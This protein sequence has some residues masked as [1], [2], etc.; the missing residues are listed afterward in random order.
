MA[1]RKIVKEELGQMDEA[2]LDR[3]REA[4]RHLD[5]AFSEVNE[6]WYEFIENPVI[7]EYVNGYNDDISLA[8]DYPFNTSFDELAQAVTVWLEKQED[9]INIIK[10]RNANT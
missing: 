4:L 2:Y 5:K 10:E 8:D 3:L 6:C 9:N 7:D 1:V